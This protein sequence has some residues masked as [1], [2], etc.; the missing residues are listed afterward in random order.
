MFLDSSF[1]DKNLKNQLAQKM[2]SIRNDVIELQ[3][4]ELELKNL[5]VKSRVLNQKK[6]VVESR[7]QTF[8][9]TRE[10]H[11][12]KF[13]DTAIIIEKKEKPVY[14]KPKDK[15]TDSIQVMKNMGIENAEE[16]LQAILQ[17]RKG[18]LVPSDR[19]KMKKIK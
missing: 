15:D 18:Q 8:L 2:S 7:I 4:I 10:Q 5:R 3:R 13:Q 19:V 9:H 1:I 12:V 16:V 14:K 17:A 6:K 11:G